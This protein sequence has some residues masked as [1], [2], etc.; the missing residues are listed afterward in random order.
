M[1]YFSELIIGDAYRDYCSSL[2]L[3]L[4]W[5]IEDLRSRLEELSR[6][7]YGTL[8]LRYM[9]VRLSEEDLACIP[10]EYFSRG[11]DILD[12]IEI[13][14]KKLAAIESAEDEMEDIGKNKSED[15][16]YPGQLSIWDILNTESSSFTSQEQELVTAA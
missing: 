16:E 6:G 10:P 4:K 7:K 8:S 2:K 13:A 14:E 3:Q 15:E 1:G 9:G 5:R 11:I 12:A